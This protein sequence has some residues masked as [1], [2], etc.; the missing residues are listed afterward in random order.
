[1]S[2]LTKIL[3]VLVA[4]VAIVLV[5]III[6]FVSNQENYRAK[7]EGLE[8]KIAS[9]EAQNRVEQSVAT[10][11]QQ[12]VE[13][14]EE[15]YETKNNL[16]LGQLSSVKSELNDTR[17]ELINARRLGAEQGAQVKTLS[18]ANELLAKGNIDL[19][20]EVADQRAELLS[21][22]TKLIDLGDVLAQRENEI[23]KFEQLLR[24][25][26]EEVTALNEKLSTL[27]T[28]LEK[29]GPDVLA[30]VQGGGS[31][32]EKPIQQMPYPVSGQITHVTNVQ[33]QTLVQINLGSKDRV[34]ENTEFHIGQGL[35]KNYAGTLV[36]TVVRESSAAGIVTLK[37]PG[38]DI[39]VGDGVYSGVQ[40]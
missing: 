20:K 8:T 1:M 9:L 25:K 28:N 24:V 21:I 16:L 17:S 15:E 34:S 23:R 11:R 6:P 2:F 38:V 29:E 39:N 10:M 12:K 19:Q 5:S 33:D 14:I 3:V 31:T 22:Q 30:R 32:D 7:V 37:K 13:Q 40:N 26:T 27:M 18:S 4:I 36:I 35:S